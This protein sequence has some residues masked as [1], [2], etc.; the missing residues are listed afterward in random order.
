MK[1]KSIFLIAS[2]ICFFMLIS[3]VKAQVLLVPEVIQEHDQWCWA[4][5]SKCVLDYYGTSVQQCE[6]A[7]YTRNTSTLNF[8]PTNCC[9]NPNQGCNDWNYN[10]GS[11]GGTI[12]DILL[13]FGGITTTNITGVLSQSQWQSEMNN[14]SPLII[15]IVNNGVGHFVVGYGKVGSDYYTMDPWFN[16]GYT[17]STYNWILTQ[18][19]SVSWTHTQKLFYES[20]EIQDQTTKKKLLKTTD[21]LGRETHNQNQP[22]IYFYNDGTVEKKLIIE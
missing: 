16:E 4:A 6:I 12:E 13:N 5:V 10:W 22:L 2:L 8:G 17:I 19:G 11:Y 1:N 15:R 9:V 20:T 7:E 3:S 21:L 18:G 14:N